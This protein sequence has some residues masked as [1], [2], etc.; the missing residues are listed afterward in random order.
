[1]ETL[2]GT[3]D[4][5]INTAGIT[6]IGI[7][8]GAEQPRIDHQ[9]AATSIVV[10]AAG[11]HIK[12]MNFHSTTIATAI[13]I[14]LGAGAA[15]FILEDCVISDS[16]TDFEFVI[17]L[18]LGAEAERCTVRNCRFESVTGNTGATSAIAITAGVVDRLTIEGCHIWGD[19]DNAG[20][21]STQINTSA[22][23]RNNSITNNETG[24]HAIELTG[25]MTGDLIDNFLNADTY[26]SVL[27]PGSM[28]CKGNMQTV[29][30]DVGAEDVPLVPGKSYM[31]SKTAA[32]I[33]ATDALFTVTGSPIVITSCYGLATTAIGGACTLN[34][35]V[36]ATS[37]KDYDLSTDVDIQSVDEGG[38]IIFDST[39]LEAVTTPAPIGATGAAGTPLNWL[40]VPGDIESD[41]GGDTGVITW[42]IV[43]T[44]AGPG[45]EVIPQ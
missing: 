17:G 39:I 45:C 3:T 28:R 22:L 24:D 44:A 10:T 25:A 12:N 4:I 18:N 32:V 36:N 8:E 6:I 2:V 5:T 14:D 7:G 13:G 38:L 23:I 20:I 37:G 31:R 26:G 11:V 27:D 15:D 43:F 42:Y 16:S 30:I 1:M 34:L 40:I 9:A 19:F 33:T 29:A 21:Y 41:A 35:Q